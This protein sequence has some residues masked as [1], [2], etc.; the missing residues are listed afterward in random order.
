MEARSNERTRRCAGHGNDRWPGRLRGPV[1]SARDI[2][3]RVGCGQSRDEPGRCPTRRHRAFRCRHGR[4]RPD[5]LPRPPPRCGSLRRHGPL[6][7]LCGD[8]F[9]PNDAPRR[10]LP[11]D[12]IHSPHGHGSERS[13]AS[14]RPRRARERAHRR[15][16]RRRRP[17][18]TTRSL[19]T[20]QPSPKQIPWP[21]LG[22]VRMVRGAIPSCDREHSRT[23]PSA[24]RSRAGPQ[25]PRRPAARPSDART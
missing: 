10:R 9:R 11:R 17:S 6:P 24:C 18:S 25:P 12:P 7:V 19:T 15:G 14:A 3:R 8:E 1:R 21:P 22:D 16:H 20:G 5:R 13:A 23:R 2:P 4:Q